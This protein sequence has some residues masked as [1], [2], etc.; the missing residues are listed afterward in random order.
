VLVDIMNMLSK[1]IKSIEKNIHE[2]IEDN[3][4]LHNSFELVTSIFNQAQVSK[5]QGT[6]TIIYKGYILIYNP[7]PS[8]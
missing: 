7:D 2:L 6:F 3:K 5:V 8:S 4:D 1:E